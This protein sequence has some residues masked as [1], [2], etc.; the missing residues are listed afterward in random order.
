MGLTES[1]HLYSSLAFSAAHYIDAGGVGATVEDVLYLK[2]NAISAVNTALADPTQALDTAVICAVMSLAAF[3]FV[4]GE[5]ENYIAHMAGG[6]KMI[7]L[8]GGQL[9]IE[10]W[11]RRIMRWIS[12]SST[13]WKIY[14]PYSRQV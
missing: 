1:A 8:R 4:F 5:T 11:L 6:N 13:C 3:E 14:W 10:P 2:Q 7:S 12:G 9:T